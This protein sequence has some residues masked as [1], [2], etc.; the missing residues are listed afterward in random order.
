VASA[1]RARSWYRRWEASSESSFESPPWHAL[2]APLPEGV[3]PRVSPIGS[4][5]QPGAGEQSVI[6]GW[7]SLVLELSAGAAGLRIIQVLLD[8]E[9]V[10]LSASDH[11]LFRSAPLGGQGPTQIRQESIGGRLEPDGEFRGTFW[12]VSGPEPED[13]GDPE[14]EMT[15]REP[16][17]VEVDALKALVTKLV[18]AFRSGGPS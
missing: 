10:P 4:A 1:W 7:V 13:G 18:L 3:T 12:L 5:L 11:V 15:P 9:G 14:W 8:G 16:T 6:A 2:L 17:V